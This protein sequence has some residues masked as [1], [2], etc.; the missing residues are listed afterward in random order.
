MWDFNGQSFSQ[1]NAYDFEVDFF[2]DFLRDNKY[3]MLEPLDQFQQTWHN[4]HLKEGFFFF[5][6]F[7]Q[8]AMFQKKKIQLK[9]V[10]KFV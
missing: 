10:L 4:E 5:R 9:L 7:K 6:F 3:L 2:R 8:R 1:C